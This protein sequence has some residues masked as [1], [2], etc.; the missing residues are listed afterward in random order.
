M[1]DQT[2][3]GWPICDEDSCIGVCL[4]ASPKCLAHAREEQRNA[5]L[6]Q[7]GETGVIDAR[8]VPITAALLRQ[9]LAAAP[10]DADDHPTF[11]AADFGRATF[12][13]EAGFGGATFR[14][15]AGFGGATFRANARFGE[16]TFRGTAWFGGATFYGTAG[17]AEASFRREA[18][19]DGATFRRE[20]WFDR[21]AFRDTAWFSGAIFQDLAWF[22]GATF[23]G[24]AS[25]R[26]ATFRADAR[27]GEVTFRREAWFSG[28]TLRIAHRSVSGAASSTTKPTRARWLT[29][30][31]IL[32]HFFSG[33]RYDPLRRR[34][35][36][37][38]CRRPA[39]EVHSPMRRLASRSP[40]WLERARGPP[41][42][43]SFD[44]RW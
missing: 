41:G 22:S 43:G 11:M 8:G 10:H 26:K 42:A 25:F 14:V 18:W 36:A 33:P 9:I 16:A 44:R 23:Q 21:A 12:Q 7:L 37:D 28:A 34:N 15:L 6:K 35:L 2:G 17:F 27:F 29:A 30:P 38:R 39:C 40:P 32:Q 13:A 3:I 1:T 4:D 20:A 5:T 24:L 31:A 19:F